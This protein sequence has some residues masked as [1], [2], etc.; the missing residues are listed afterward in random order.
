[1]S[2]TIDLGEL[3]LLLNEEA[4]TLE[5]PPVTDEQFYEFCARNPLLNVELTEKGNIHLMPPVEAWTDNRGFSLAYDLETWNR[6]LSEPGFTFGPTAGFKLPSGAIRAPDASW[7]SKAR[8]DALPE[9]DRRPYPHLCPDFVVEVMSPSD[10]LT[11]A[12]GK[13]VNYIA[14]GARLGWLIDRKN[15]AVYIY[16]PDETDP[17]P[18][19]DPQ[20][21]SGDPELPGF[22]ADLARVFAD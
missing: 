10:R 2:I 20:T 4:A 19:N 1:M 22:T 3:P 12:K 11:A 17:K 21:L 14:N 15:R 18:L 7:L 6:S 5:L 16:R 8:W 13:M 9:E